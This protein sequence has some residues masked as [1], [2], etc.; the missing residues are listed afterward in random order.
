[1][2]RAGSQLC[3]YGAGMPSEVCDL[4]EVGLGGWPACVITPPLSSLSQGRGPW[5]HRLGCG[6]DK[7]RFSAVFYSWTLEVTGT[8][9]Q[10][11]PGPSTMSS[12]LCNIY[13]GIQSYKH[14]FF[15]LMSF[16][17]YICTSIPTVPSFCPFHL[18]LS[19]T[20]D[21][22]FMTHLHQ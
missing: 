17:Y 19:Y 1:M 3:I 11:I 20:Y 2:G 9:L 18:N 6:C 8:H 21:S 7:V 5:D 15:K 22:F 16:P 10:G 12:P 14:L 4:F 13:S